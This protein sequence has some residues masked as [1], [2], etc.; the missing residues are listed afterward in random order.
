MRPVA[1]FGSIA[2]AMVLWLSTRMFLG[3]QLWVWKVSCL[4]GAWAPIWAAALIL[5]VREVGDREDG[6]FMA[7]CVRA[8]GMHLTLVWMLGMSDWLRGPP[9]TPPQWNSD[10]GMPLVFLAFAPVLALSV[11]ALQWTR[12]VAARV[13]AYAQAR[14]AGALH[15]VVAAPSP[16]RDADT[17]L[18]RGLLP[19]A[20]PSFAPVFAGAAGLVAMWAALSTSLSP[21]A[22]LV[23]TA[24]ALSMA[25]LRSA[26]A[27]APS[28][29]ALVAVGGLLV[30]RAQHLD[31]AALVNRAMLWP[32]TA[33]VGLVLYLGLLEGRLRLDRA[34]RSASR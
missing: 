23:G 18:R 17:E 26:R 10:V 34:L 13:A 31:G 22:V 21:G 29:C 30:T 9:H 28:V 7:W 20:P 5:Y 8:V 32:V 1:L 6:W 16:Y 11:A 25:S 4:L 14:Q 19:S 3:D 24:V 2:A 15:L 33:L 12:S 27:L